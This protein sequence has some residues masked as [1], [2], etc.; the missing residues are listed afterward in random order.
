M[1][2]RYYTQA[3]HAKHALRTNRCTTAWAEV[4]SVGSQTPNLLYSRLASIG[5]GFRLVLHGFPCDFVDLNVFSCVHI[6]L[7]VFKGLVCPLSLPAALPRSQ[8][9]QAPIFL[10]HVP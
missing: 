2:T 8:A 1:S 9:K 6:I 10:E 4:G 5:E 3:K 7:D